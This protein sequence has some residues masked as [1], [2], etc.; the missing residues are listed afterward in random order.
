M[1]EDYDMIR[2][3]MYLPCTDQSKNWGEFERIRY[4]SILSSADEIYYISEEPYKKGCMKKRNCAMAE[5]SD[6]C[7]AFLKKL[8]SGTAQTVKMAEEKGIHIVNI[9]ERS[10]F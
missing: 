6:M 8:S 9:A 2:L 4:D 3:V 1:R 10:I 5:A 7:I